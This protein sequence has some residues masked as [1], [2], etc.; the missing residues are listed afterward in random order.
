[1]SLF[2]TI[3]HHPR[4]LWIR[5]ALFQVH[6]WVGVLL[7]LYVVVISLSGSIL[8]FQDEIRLASIQHPSL[9]REQLPPLSSVVTQAHDRFPSA[10]LTYVGFPQKHAP[11]WTL[12]LTKENGRPDLAYADATTGSPLVQR[13]RL[14][15]D[16]VLDLHVYLLAGRTGFVVNCIAGAGLLLLAVTGMILWWPGIK[17]WKRALTVKL[18]RGWKR[19]NYDLHNVIGM[20][21]L[22]IVSWWGIT[23]IYF[24]LPAQVS[25][26]VDT[27]SPLEGMKAPVPH[28]PA[29]SKEVT[30]IDTILAGLPAAERTRIGGVSLSEKPGSAVTI[31]VDR[32]ESGDFSHRDILTFDSH[33]GKLLTVWHYGENHTLGDWIIW[34]MYPLHFGTVWGLGVKVLWALLGVCLALLS[35][36]GLLM[37]WNRKLSKYFAASSL[38]QRRAQ[39]SGMQLRSIR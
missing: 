20:A 34:L 25:A 27:I 19:T 22:A 18:Q 31:Y 10:K 9:D 12:Y 30:P 6:L 11:W 32:Q 36:T 26:V 24:L 35:V 3:V 16:F 13:G 29:A 37:Y 4:K 14:F 23:A 28:T 33:T 17:L 38:V 1:M 21:T 5:R 2:T 39:V 7:S 15:I 8:V